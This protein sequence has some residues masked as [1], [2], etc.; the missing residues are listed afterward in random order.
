MLIALPL[1]RFSEFTSVTKSSKGR[2]TL[3]Q[4]HGNIRSMGEFSMAT[5]YCLKLNPEL[6]RHF[7]EP[8]A[9]CD[10]NP[11]GH[12]IPESS[13]GF[14]SEIVHDFQEISNG[15]T[16]V[17]RTPKKPEYLIARSQL[18]ER[19]PLGSGPIQF[20]MESNNS[21]PPRRN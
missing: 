4:I 7:R 12:S 21:F 11:M 10:Q 19:G 15:R 13:N 3:K 8:L 14:F 1:M 17:S 20:L 18:T 9:L 2:C 16:H 6:H 5:C